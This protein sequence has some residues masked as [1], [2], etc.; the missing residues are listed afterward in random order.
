MLLVFL[1]AAA[2]CLV[3]WIVYLAHTLPDHFDTGQWRTAWVGFDVGLVCCFA[4][5]AWLGLRRRRSAVPLLAATA[6]LLVC[7]G[8]FD[9]V[10]DWSSPDR[11][12]SLAL[13]VFAEVPIAVFLLMAARRLLTGDLRMRA[14]TLRDIEIHS[15]PRHH[16][17]LRELPATDA[18]LTG[19]FGAGAVTLLG[20]LAEAGYVRRHRDGRWRTVPQSVRE[21]RPEDFDEADQRR[22]ADYLDAKYGREIE[23]LTWA[24]RHRDEFGPWGKAHRGLAWLTEPELRHLEA[25]YQDLVARYCRLRRDPVP[26]AR[27][28]TVRLYA[29]P[30]PGA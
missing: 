17:V 22:V 9:V 26:E 15:D 18:E 8:W 11:W 5:A 16:Q 25:E 19:R 7:D 12:T 27:E 13:A 6:A 21:P 23:L 3:P 14:L 29:F 30:V 20:T 1:G 4:A 2:V 24:A 10:L 28:V